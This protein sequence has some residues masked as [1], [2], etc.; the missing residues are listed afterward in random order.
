MFD[1]RWILN[2]LG[3]CSKCIVLV[4]QAEQE[5][6]CPVPDGTETDAAVHLVSQYIDVCT[7]R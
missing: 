4:E 7:Y 5:T 3:M 2:I 1:A 6:P